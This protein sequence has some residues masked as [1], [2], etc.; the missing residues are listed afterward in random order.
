[1]IRETVDPLGPEALGLALG[2]LVNLV[3]FAAPLFL[4]LL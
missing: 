4:E 2:G 1:M 3:A